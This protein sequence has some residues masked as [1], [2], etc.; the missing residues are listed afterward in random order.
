M[1]PGNEGKTLTEEKND[2]DM[3]YVFTT[4]L[5]VHMLFI[6]DFEC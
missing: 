3:L 4:E 1:Q 6:F 5:Q 2:R